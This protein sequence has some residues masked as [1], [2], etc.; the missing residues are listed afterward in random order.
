MLNFST[1]SVVSFRLLETTLIANNFQN[2]TILASDVTY[3]V[4]RLSNPELYSQHEAL[5]PYFKNKVNNVNNP[6]AY[7]FIIVRLPNGTVIPVGKPWID[8]PSYQVVDT[9]RATI[10]I[11][12]YHLEWEAPIKDLLNNLGASYTVTLGD[13]TG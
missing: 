1:G 2:V 12:N 7:H 3:E 13:I 10:E 4:A 6:S 5:F 8:E 9:K 11:S